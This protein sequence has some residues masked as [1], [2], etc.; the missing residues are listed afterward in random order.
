MNAT[1]RLTDPV[2]L[3]YEGN[4]EGRGL[5]FVFTRGEFVTCRGLLHR[6]GELF[7]YITEAYLWNDP[8]FVRHGKSRDC[9]LG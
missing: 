8:V 2:T 7:L 1:A 6:N 9:E 3:G 4:N 5:S